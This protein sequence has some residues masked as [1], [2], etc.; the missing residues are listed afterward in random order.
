MNIVT[1]G[2]RNLFRVKKRIAGYRYRQYNVLIRIAGR[3][4]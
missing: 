3:D 2:Y 1:Y 4:Q